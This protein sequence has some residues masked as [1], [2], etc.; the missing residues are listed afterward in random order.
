MSTVGL[1]GQNLFGRTRS[2]LLA[3]L[4]GHGDESFHLRQLVRAVGTGNGAVQRELKL[5]TDMGLIVRKAQGNQVRYQANSQSPTFSEIKGLITKTV[6]VHDVIRSA[7]VT[8]GSEIE[9]AF[10]YGSVARHAERGSSDVDLMVVGDV[11][12]SEI[13]SLLGP[14]QK[15]LGREVNPTVFPVSEF[16]TKL[17]AG[18]HFLRS[19]MKEKKLFVL[20]TEHE[21]AKLAAKQLAG[22]ART[23]R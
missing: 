9:V 10:V 23:K 7:L 1:S 11:P 4:Y 6:G 3:M 12:F 19:I 13:V 2:A 18:N 22:P 17:A 16:R 8:L 5:L 15:A 21:F 14:A 20:G